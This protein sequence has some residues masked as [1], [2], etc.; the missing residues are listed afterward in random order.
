MIVLLLGRTGLAVD[1]KGVFCSGEQPGQ[2][3]NEI[4][5]RI[6]HDRLSILETPFSE[7]LT[8]R[9][10]LPARYREGKKMGR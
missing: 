8:I 9:N 7:K 10:L 2:R 6:S 1:S 4:A 3:S 5:I